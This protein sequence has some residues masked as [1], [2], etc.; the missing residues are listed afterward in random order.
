MFRWFMI[1]GIA[2]ISFSILVQGRVDEVIKPDGGLQPATMEVEKA[3][4]V[5]FMRAQPPESADRL[6]PAEERLKGRV[7]PEKGT[8]VEGDIVPM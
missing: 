4:S 8:A 1:I 3:G 2:L 6:T 7:P 5:M